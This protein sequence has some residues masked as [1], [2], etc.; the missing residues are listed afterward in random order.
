MLKKKNMSCRHFLSMLLISCVL[1]FF[2]MNKTAHAC[3][4]SSCSCPDVSI[5]TCLP[6]IGAHATT[7]AAVMAYVDLRI[8]EHEFFL[9]Q[10]F[11]KDG[12]IP[13]LREFAHQITDGG[14]KQ[15][16]TR[17]SIKTAQ[18]FDDGKTAIGKHVV[19]EMENL[20]P[21]EIH[22]EATTFISGLSA[23]EADS[24]RE[25]QENMAFALQ[26]ALGNKNAP[27]TA[28]RERM[29]HRMQSFCK[30][31][32]PMMGGGSISRTCGGVTPPDQDQRR[33]LAASII[34]KPSIES[35]DR[36]PLQVAIMAMFFP[37]QPESID[38]EMFENRNMKMAYM[39]HR[40]VLSRQML[41]AH[42]FQKSFQDQLGGSDVAVSYQNA[43]ASNVGLNATEIAQ[44]IGSNPSA[45][46]QKDLLIEM[47][48]TPKSAI[49]TT[50]D[51]KG[52]ILRM[53]NSLQS[54]K[55]ALLYDSLE[56][57][58]CN[59]LML[60]QLVNDHLKVMSGDLQERLDIIEARMEAEKTKSKLVKTISP[61]QKT[62]KGG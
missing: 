2:F 3:A 53:S 54:N 33:F 29:T 9:L 52:G 60:S 28:G 37:D 13:A 20:M 32:D 40:A 18:M 17:A 6:A 4:C 30:Y 47:S 50:I 25:A 12:L 7:N 8:L 56:I 26:N 36:E 5:L 39:Q 27:L 21:S 23:A 49:N 44:K 11:M 43:A 51:K 16:E 14:F 38:E 24:E 57:L 62:N 61:H 59:E 45:S 46:A 48:M 41:A 19:K 31:A 34:Q 22:C 42:C 10:T 35:A 55:M 15:A 1:S 58:H